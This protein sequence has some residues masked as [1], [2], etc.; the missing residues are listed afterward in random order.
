MAKQNRPPTNAT[1][2]APQIL[3]AFVVRLFECAGTSTDDARL[4]ARL[5]VENDLR[6]VFTH[7]TQ[8]LS[9][10]IPKIIQ[11][12]VNPAPVM[13]DVHESPAALVID[14]DGGLGYFPCYRGTQR[15]IAKARVCGIAALTTRNHYHFGAAGNYTRLALS[16]NCIGIAVSSHQTSRQAGESIYNTVSNSPISVALPTKGQSPVVLDMGNTLL[17]FDRSACLN[18]PYPFFKAMGLGN[19]VQLLGGVF[20]GIYK[21]ELSESVSR[22]KSNQGAFIIVIDVE[23]FM[24]LE[25][26][27]LEV[28]RYVAE[29]RRMEP[30]PGTDVAEVAGG[31]EWHWEHEN[32]LEGILVSPEHQKALSVVANELGVDTPF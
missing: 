22:W 25:E 20:A 15:L 14:G 19:I 28:D 11:G 21:P 24:P 27:Q 10:Y 4:M 5:L 8:Q 13:R 3:E 23:H 30:L 2:I 7:G 26:L 18:N 31:V 1:R 17:D 29:V 12:E 9:D 16:E 32:K 6:C